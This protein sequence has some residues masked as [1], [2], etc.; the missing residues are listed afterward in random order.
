MRKNKSLT[1]LKK[2]MQ[3]RPSSAIDEKKV[4]E[5]FNNLLGE[6]KITKEVFVLDNLYLQ[7]F[8]LEYVEYTTGLKNYFGL[9]KQRVEK[10][11][12]YS[13][14]VMKRNGKLISIKSFGKVS[15][16]N[17]EIFEKL[18][19]LVRLAQYINKNRELYSLEVAMLE[20]I[21]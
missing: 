19:L 21:S 17:D 2:E 13:K 4:E 1:A 12:S 10:A 16:M 6:L 11:D 20:I 8:K 7:P 18:V 9:D 3:R 15:D 5:V 14:L